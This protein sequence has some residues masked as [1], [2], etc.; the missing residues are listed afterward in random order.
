MRSAV[1]QAVELLGGIGSWVQPGQKILLKPNLLSAR[2]PE[3][4]VTTHPAVVEAVVELC[5]QAGAKVSL[6]DSPP[7][8]GERESSYKRLLQMTGMNGVAERTGAEIVRFE[9]AVTQIECPEGRY[10]KKFDVARAVVDAD[11]LISIPKLKTHGLTYLTGAVKNIFGCIP[12]K[13]KAFFHAQ[14][15]DDR[16][17]FAQMLVDLLRALPPQ[18]SIMD[19]VVGMEGDGPV[20]G[21]I[22]PVGLILASVDPV[23]LDAVASAVLG[24]DPMIVETTRIASSEGLGVA[25]LKK[26]EVLGEPIE[27]VTCS[28]FIEPRSKS[29]WTDIPRPIRQLLKSQ[30]VPFP[31]VTSNCKSCGACE[32]ACPVQAISNGHKRPHI[33][34][35]KCIRCY[36]CREV[37][38]HQGLELKIGKL[39]ACIQAIGNIRRTIIHK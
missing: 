11:V 4:A 22:R 25:D 39:S 2:L 5:L 6:G 14:A 31:V 20:D 19:A 16:E 28:G 37:C 23:A 21:K 32:Q 17:T 15:G 27:N 36:C 34:L 12:G 18:L 13:R 35:S 3:A 1:F 33:D 38:E 9:E 8:A 7:L 26:I 10:Y 29:L 30:L 24:I